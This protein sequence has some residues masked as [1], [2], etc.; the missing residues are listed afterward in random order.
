[1]PM[2][3]LTSDYGLRDPYRGM[4]LAS[5]YSEGLQDPVVE[6]THQ[7]SPKALM[8]AAFVI[9]QAYHSFP[10]GSI[11]LLLVD[12]LGSQG[13]FLAM[14][15]RDQYFIAPDHG[16]LSLICDLQKPSDLHEIKL[17]NRGES[18]FPARDY[19][20]KAA[21]HLAR[22]GS[23]SLLGPQTSEMKQLVAQR[24]TR[25][26]NTGLVQGVVLYIDHYGNAISNIPADLFR[27]VLQSQ[28]FKINIYRNKPLSRLS[29]NYQDRAQD[30][31][32]A[33]INSLG[34]LEISVRDGTSAQNNGAN[35]LLGLKESDPITIEF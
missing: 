3:S 14:R 22:G 21:A 31:V 13:R 25:D 23:L 35:S 6:I 24:P 2:I 27:D 11:H 34:L 9:R 4:I 16:L 17:Q 26:N 20:V 12:E 10:K 1:M 8:Q 7:I 19:L 29:S 32:L 5:L 28:K 33:L 30:G 15:F 18:L